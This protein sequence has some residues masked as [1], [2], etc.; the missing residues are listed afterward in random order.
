[1]IITNDSHLD[2]GLS[3]LHRAFITKLF[4]GRTA[5]F[6]E[7][8]TLPS[9]LTALDSA[10][11]GP[12][13][14]DPPIAESDVTYIVRGA[15]AGKSRV[16]N[17]PLRKTRLVSVIGGPH[18]DEP[19]ILYTAFGGPI[20]PREPFDPSLVEGSPEHTESVAF[21]KEHALAAL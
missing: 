7:T 15:R 12:L 2:H 1:M 17:R 11:Y 14:G 16:V 3:D 5:F 10:L 19:C 4:E 20:A 8:V 13:V 9:D 6:K 21:W 18:N